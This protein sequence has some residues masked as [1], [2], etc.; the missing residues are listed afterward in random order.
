MLDP[1]EV[2]RVRGEA[3]GEGGD[4]DSGDLRIADDVIA[5]I[6]RIAAMRVEGV[7]GLSGGLMGG[8]TEVLTKSSVR[9][10]RVQCGEKQVA[11]DIQL[12]VRYGTRIPEV[13]VRVQEEVKKSI[14]E[15]TGLQVVEVNIHVQSVVFPKD[16]ERVPK[17]R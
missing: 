17:S 12:A 10:I 1:N 16:A 11:V 2:E 15:M 3:P 6:A 9:G 7:V 14:E 13:A 4:G 5:A 8:L